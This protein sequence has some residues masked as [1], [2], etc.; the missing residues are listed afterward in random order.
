MFK[1]NRLAILDDLKNIFLHAPPVTNAGAAEEQRKGIIFNYFLGATWLATLIITLENFYR[2]L[3]LTGNDA[4]YYVAYMPSNIGGLV[5]LGLIWWGHRRYPHIMRH[6]FLLMVT[7]SVIFLF[8]LQNIDRLFAALT[9]PIIMSAFL[10]R[11]FYSFL[12]FV[13]ISVIY[14]LR[15]YMAGF[16]IADN[17]FSTVSLLSL[18]VVSVIAWLIA[19]SL[20]SALAE[21][22]ALNRELD[23]RVQDRTRRLAEALKR[24]HTAA[25]QNQTILESIADGI[26]VFNAER[27]IIVANPAANQLAGQSLQALTFNQMVTSIAADDR[28]ALQTWLPRNTPDEQSTIRFAWRGK[29]VSAGVAPMMTGAENKQV[30]AGS[31]MV[32]RD[33]TREAQLEKA[34]DLFLGMV[35]HELRTPMSAIRGYVEILL[36]LEKDTLTAEGYEYLQAINLSIRQLLTLANELIDLSRLETGE[37]D[38]YCRWTDL[39]SLV[40]EVAKIV[41][42]EFSS[43]NLSLT[44]SI[45]PGLPKL[46]LDKTRISQI[47]LN[48]LSNTYKYTLQGGATV[49]VSQSDEWVNVSVADT[50]V[51]IKEADQPNLFQRFFRADDQVVQ[52]AGGTGLGLSIS[53]GLIELHHGNL[54]FESTYGVGTTFVMSLP[55]NLPQEAK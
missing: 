8:E 1:L 43:R 33:I 34:K 51:G 10:I 29:T 25:V 7:T 27:Q 15:L 3:T 13:F 49:S 17:E 45:E 53:K 39:A 22:R 21:T 36:D 2:L 18:M 48:L 35:S 42:H 14:T 28:A 16:S 11:P 23:R 20:D 4:R 47:L 9:L 30:S 12:Y 19:Y 52:Q 32:L 6:A 5:L 26:I 41:R 38:L 46:Y 55:K 37:I 54:T 50:G 40:T 31:V 44:V 24:E